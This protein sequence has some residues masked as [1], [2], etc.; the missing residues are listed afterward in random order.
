LVFAFR[1]EEVNKVN[2]FQPE[3]KGGRPIISVPGL[4][5]KLFDW[6]TATLLLSAQN[7]NQALLAAMDASPAR[8]CFRIKRDKRYQGISYQTFQT[9]AL[10]LA[11]F[12]RTQNMI[13]VRIR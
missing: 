13:T 9:L 10:R 6:Q 4:A 1:I 8:M 12:S 2:L 3:A 11:T 5:T 7:L